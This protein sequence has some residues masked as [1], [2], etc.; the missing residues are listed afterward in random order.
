MASPRTRRVMKELRPKY[1]NNSCFECNGHNPQW[2]SVSYGIWICLEC[3]GKHRGLGVHLSFVRSISMDKWKDIELEKMKCGGNNN[4]REFIKSQ[5]DYNPSWTFQEKYNSKA[6]ALYR[7]K[8]A[9]EAQGKPWSAETSS[10]RNHVPYTASLRV[11]SSS[12]MHTSSS[13]PSFDTYNSGGAKSESYGSGYQ[14]AGTDDFEFQYGMSKSEVKNKTDNYFERRKMENASRPEGLPPNQGGRYTGFGNT[15]AEMP[16]S[17]SQEFYNN[18][19]SS[20]TSGWS[21]FSLGASKFASATK[22]GAIKFGS[23]ASQKTQEYA[24]TV[25]DSVIKPTREK[26]HDG[27]LL[28][29]LSSGTKS[30]ASKVA[31][32]TSKGWEG[33]TAIWSEEPTALDKAEGAP[34]TDAPLMGDTS[35]KQERDR[36]RLMDPDKS[37]TPLLHDV[38]TPPRSPDDNWGWGDDDT[39]VSAP[40]TQKTDN[41]AKIANDGWDTWGN[42]DAEQGDLLLDFDDNPKP[43]KTKSTKSKTK[44]NVNTKPI[45]SLEDD[46]NEDGGWDDAAWEAVEQEVKNPKKGD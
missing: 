9:T 46:W 36:L 12:S 39:W 38:P 10:A 11:S 23:A 34:G 30:W 21:A 8:I 41:D 25:N 6:A 17:E 28:S 27:T 31:G 45:K 14:A 15:P 24:Q 32:N 19:V 42:D 37:D 13:S 29:D 20:L 5:P 33:F 4:A 1:G 7:D 22:E 35:G 44:T 2:V 40:L 16:K 18:A 43:S 3:S 26:V